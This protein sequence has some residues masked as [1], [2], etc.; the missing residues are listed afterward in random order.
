[1]A[2]YRVLAILG[3]LAAVGAAY[4]TKGWE[5][6]MGDRLRGDFRSRSLRPAPAGD[7]PTVTP[8]APADATKPAPTKPAPAAPVPAKP[9]APPKPK[10]QV[11]TVENV[12][13]VTSAGAEDFDP[14]IFGKG[15]TD[16]RVPVNEDGEP[17]TVWQ[18]TKAVPIN[19]FAELG[20]QIGA[21][22]GQPVVIAADGKATWLWVRW[23]LETCQDSY[24]QNIYL[25]AAL[26]GEPKGL[27][28]IAVK[29]PNAKNAQLPAPSESFVVTL[30]PG[31]AAGAPTVTADGKP[32]AELAK[33]VAAAWTAW[34]AKRKDLSDTSNADRTRAVLECG[35]GATM[36]DVIPV[37]AAMRGAGI[38]TERYSG[39]IPKRPR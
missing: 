35:K 24:V 25:G 17:T 34:S 4:A 2:N 30:K 3:T 38:R 36:A 5:E 15:Y 6:P 1:M 31:A 13:L 26:P 39:T 20:R 19:T 9:D 28:G 23:L 27:R 21:K 22:Q 12:V 14:D 32:V 16:L 10:M 11:V 7:A 8:A 37:I 18:G 29:M 33:D